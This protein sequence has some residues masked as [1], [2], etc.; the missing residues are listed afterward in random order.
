MKRVMVF[1]TFDGVHDGHRHLFT[2]AVGRGDEV[3]VVVARDEHVLELKGHLPNNLIESRM[4]A[5]ACESDVTKVILGDEEL[6][7][8]EVIIEHEP[9]VILLGYDQDELRA[10]LRT[11]LKDQHLTSIA[12]ENGSAHM[13]EIFKSSFLAQSEEEMSIL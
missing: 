10:D 4:D 7:S 12:L 3:F 9:S 8:Y 1:G 2:E 11:W 13:P 6:G 5:L